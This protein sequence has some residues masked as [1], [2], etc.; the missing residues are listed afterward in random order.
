MND[1]KIKGVHCIPLLGIESE[2]ILIISG[3][4]K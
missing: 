4:L 2:R 3:Y 1:I